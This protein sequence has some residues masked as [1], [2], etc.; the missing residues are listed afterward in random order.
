[1][2]RCA[3][4]VVVT[5]EPRSASGVAVRGSAPDE[6]TCFLRRL[7]GVGDTARP[8]RV[9]TTPGAVSPESA[10][11]SASSDAFNTVLYLSARHDSLSSSLL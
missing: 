5:A 9:Q 4:R 10:P 11:Y 8:E 3:E 1:M 2:R 7:R 6:H